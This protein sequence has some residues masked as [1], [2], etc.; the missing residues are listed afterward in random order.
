MMLPQSWG[1]FPKLLQFYRVGSFSNTSRVF[2]YF[3]RAQSEE[4]QV[5]P[6]MGNSVTSEISGEAQPQDQVVSI[7]DTGA[8]GPNAEDR[9]EEQE[10]SDQV[11]PSFRNLEGNENHPVLPSEEPAFM[12]LDPARVVPQGDDDDSFVDELYPLADDH[13][14]NNRLLILIISNNNVRT[15]YLLPVV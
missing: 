13:D 2:F 3:R 10:E 8:A 12:D 7:M 4:D 9:Q 6:E 15:L 5:V 1:A 11:V 14:E